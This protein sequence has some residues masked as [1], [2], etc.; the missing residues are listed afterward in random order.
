MSRDRKKKALKVYVI[1]K[2]KT[3]NTLL[4]KILTHVEIQAGNT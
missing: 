1:F 3:V 2:Q 4:V